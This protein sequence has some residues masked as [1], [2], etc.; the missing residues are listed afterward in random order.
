MDS[1]KQILNSALV[2]LTILLIYIIYL[3]YSR[4]PDTELDA[5]GD[6]IITKKE[7]SDYIKKELERRSSS[8]P[9]T[10]G[11]MKS[12]LSGVIRGGLM[13]LVLGGVEGAAASAIVLGLINPIIT[14]IEYAY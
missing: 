11:I 1:F 9:S 12:A 13:G 2:V 14:G 5:D 6:G 7:V 8:P 10:R 3:S 4:K